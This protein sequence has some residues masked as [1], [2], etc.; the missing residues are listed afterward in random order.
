MQNISNPRSFCLYYLLMLIECIIILNLK[1]KN[2]I[3][4][5][6]FHKIE[7]YMVRLCTKFRNVEGI[8]FILFCTL[9]ILTPSLGNRKKTYSLREE[10]FI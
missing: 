5:L 4:I 1:C 6:L 7:V 9:G 2:I 8:F 10:N 3:K